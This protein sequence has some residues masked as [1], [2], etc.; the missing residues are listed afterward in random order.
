MIIKDMNNDDDV[1]FCVMIIFCFCAV[2]VCWLFIFFVD[3]SFPCYV[4]Y[5]IFKVF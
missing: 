5:M 4:L 3:F 2:E 1:F